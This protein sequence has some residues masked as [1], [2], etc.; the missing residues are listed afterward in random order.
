MFITPNSLL[1]A[2]TTTQIH[3]LPY[4]ATARITDILIGAVIGLIGVLLVGS[5][6]ASSLLPHLIAKTIRSQS[7]LFFKL[8][9]EQKNE[10]TF[11]WSKER[12]KMRTNLINLRTVYT[13]ALGEISNNK[14]ELEYLSPVIF[15]M[16]QLGYLL[17]SSSKNSNR[18]VLSDEILAYFLLVFETMA[19]S[20]E[21]HD[22]V[23][24]KKVPE[25]EGYSKL[26]KEIISLQDALQ[27]VQDQVNFALK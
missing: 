7:Q 2:E 8:F 23:T 16:E 22:S 24:K 19:K 10:S 9:S 12:N 27:L 1:M 26:Q 5:R 11:D 20:V 21:Q 25:I 13:T 3:N 14:T 17:E 6:S 15:S 4:F 18:P